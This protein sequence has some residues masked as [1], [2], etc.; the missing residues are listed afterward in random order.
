MPGNYNPSPAD[1]AAASTVTL[2]VDGDPL[3]RDDL[4]K[5]LAPG[6]TPKGT[7]G[8][9]LDQTAWLRKYAPEL[10]QTT[11]VEQSLMMDLTGSNLGKA[12]LPT[13]N[14]I[15]AGDSIVQMLT[16]LRHG[17]K[18]TSVSFWLHPDSHGSLPPTMPTFTVQRRAVAG[19][20]AVSIGPGVTDPSANTTV[21]D[22]S[23]TIACPITA[24]NGPGGTSE[25][26]DLT[27]YVYYGVFVAESGGAPADNNTVVSGCVMTV[28]Y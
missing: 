13:S 8:L 18:L 22:T 7:I 16:C 28:S 12:I 5:E 19:G 9:A 21:Y 17:M 25:I 14:G 23:H 4:Y 15:T 3:N 27:Q 2:L 6:A 11:I 10:G 26:V 20:S 1:P 24:G